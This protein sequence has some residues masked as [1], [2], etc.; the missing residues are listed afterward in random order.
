MEQFRRE[1]RA[2]ARQK[3]RESF[4]LYLFV[5]CALIAMIATVIFSIKGKKLL[6]LLALSVPT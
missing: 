5:C 2:W 1:Y 3:E 6:E 4:R